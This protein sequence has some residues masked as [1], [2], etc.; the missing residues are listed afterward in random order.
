[1]DVKELIKQVVNVGSKIYKVLG[2]G[3]YKDVYAE[4]II[5]ELSEIGI[6]A[7]RQKNM[8][9]K[10][11]T[12]EF[13]SAYQVDVIVEDIL[14]VG[15]QPVDMPVDVYC[16]HI[17]TYAK[18]SNSSIGLILDFNVTD[19]RRGVK[20]IQKPSPKPVVFPMSYLKYYYDK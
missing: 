4:C 16:K 5:Y 10:Y 1:M 20:I 9:L 14:V 19:F 7:E 12:L 11:R 6:N 18:H 8:S 15:I 17:Q 13:D 3:L 2:S